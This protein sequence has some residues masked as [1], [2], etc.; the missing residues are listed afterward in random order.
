MKILEGS[1]TK[2]NYLDAGL[3]IKSNEDCVVQSQSN[4][5]VHTGLFINVPE[6]HVGLVWSRSG[7]AK[8]G[9]VVGAGCIDSGYNGEVLVLLFNHGMADYHVKT[10]DRIAQLLTIPVNL[11]LYTQVTSFEESD[12]GSNGFGSTGI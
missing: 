4:L 3:D 7:L 8:L 6:D 11:G 12:R 1:L 2:T 5:L 10:G 9:I